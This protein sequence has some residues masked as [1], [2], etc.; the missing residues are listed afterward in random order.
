M[1]G[2]LITFEGV[3]GGGKSTQIPR[4]KEWILKSPWFFQLHEAGIC[5]DVVTTREPGGTSLGD[6]LRT[7]LL[8]QSSSEPIYDRTELLLYMADRVQHVEGY[9]RPA[10]QKG[11]IILC[12]RYTDSTVAYQGYGRGVDSNLIHQLNYIA[13]S[14]LYGDL[15]LWLDVE[16]ELG[17][18][19]AQARGVQ[20]RME[21]ASL[22]F[23]QRV[24]QGFQDLAYQNP[25]RMV[26]IDANKSEDDAQ[27]Q[28]QRAIAKFLQQWY[29]S[30][31][32]QRG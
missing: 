29:F 24:R 27:V 20:D 11:M 13:T 14:G 19:R 6:Q 1:W 9:I 22:E 7:M 2:K 10:L 8:T 25:H 4:I 30:A 32:G 28:V 31:L 18:Q 16:P 26:R 12:D 15:T 23:H 21:E 5:T 17:L 3:E